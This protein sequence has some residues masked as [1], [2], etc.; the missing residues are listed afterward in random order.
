MCFPVAA[1]ILQSFAFAVKFM[2]RRVRSYLYF[3]IVAF[4]FAA[5][6]LVFASFVLFVKACEAAGERAVGWSCAAYAAVFIAFY[7]Y[8][9]YSYVRSNND[10]VFAI[11][12]ISLSLDTPRN[13][14]QSNSQ[15]EIKSS[16]LSL[17]SIV[18]IINTDP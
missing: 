14:F 17:E 4:Q 8:V 3:V 6:G 10:T 1:L 16:S 9:I 18:K 11:K 15:N 7:V 13:D 5:F 12:K 2:F